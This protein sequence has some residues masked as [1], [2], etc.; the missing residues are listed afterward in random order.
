MNFILDYGPVEVL[1]FRGSDVARESFS[2]EPLQFRSACMRADFC[3][4]VRYGNGFVI[5]LFTYFALA[6]DTNAEAVFTHLS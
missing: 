3:I 5:V 2:T 4:C 6:H 1:H